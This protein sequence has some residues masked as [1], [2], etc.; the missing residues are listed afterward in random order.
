MMFAQ[1]TQPSSYELLWAAIATSSFALVG[2]IVTAVLARLNNKAAKA[3]AAEIKAEL[4]TGNGHTAGQG[5][6]RL[7]DTLWR[8]EVRLDAIEVEVREV[9]QVLTPEEP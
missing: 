8:H 6:A 7:E 9:R 3:I 4:K 1:A 5:I 2:V